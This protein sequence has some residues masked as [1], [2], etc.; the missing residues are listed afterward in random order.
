LTK[1]FNMCA[2]SESGG[3]GSDASLTTASNPEIGNYQASGVRGGRGDIGGRAEGYGAPADETGTRGE[4]AAGATF[5]SMRSWSGRAFGETRS[6]QDIANDQAVSEA[7]EEGRSTFKTAR[8]RQAAV[9]SYNRG[10][11]PP[12]PGSLMDSVNKPPTVGGVVGFGV[13]TL[14]GG[15]V[16]FVAG[17]AV[18]GVVNSQLGSR[19]ILG[20]N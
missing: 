7:L 10:R 11:S 14:I 12:T 6:D 2:G 5:N 13:S 19:S 16:G 9:A 20:G 3:D 17:R 15:P 1:E 18:S 4:V 8:G